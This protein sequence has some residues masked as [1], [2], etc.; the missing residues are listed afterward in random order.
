MGGTCPPSEHGDPPG[1]PPFEIGKKI[2]ELNSV[3]IFV[4][5]TYLLLSLKGIRIQLAELFDFV[6]L[7]I[8]V[9]L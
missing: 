3:A 1:G 5:Q 6:N 2:T 9:N 7:L 8:F 4:Y